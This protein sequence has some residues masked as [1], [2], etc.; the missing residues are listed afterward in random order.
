MSMDSTAIKAGGK[1]IG[2]GTV[3]HVFS[4]ARRIGHVNALWF[5][6]VAFTNAGAQSPVRETMAEALADILAA[7]AS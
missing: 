7:V 4:G 1:A 3:H 5:G 6:F 2:G